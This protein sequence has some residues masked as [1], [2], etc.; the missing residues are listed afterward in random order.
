MDDSERQGLIAT[1]FILG[2]VVGGAAVAL[3]GSDQRQAVARR[4]RGKFDELLS[5]RS[6]E[7]VGS[8]V[9]GEVRGVLD[10]VGKAE[11]VLPSGRR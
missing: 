6:I 8:A 10:E 4:A 7:E 3:L 1:G 11:R 2:A 9:R 5:G